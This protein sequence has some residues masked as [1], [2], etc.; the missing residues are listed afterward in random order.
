MMTFLL[1]TLFLL[2]VVGSFAFGIAAAYWVICKFLDFFDPV[3]TTDKRTA[4][5]ALA[6]TT[7]G[8]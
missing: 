5:R 2:T 4:V 3:R 8:D 6:P 1:S 7:S